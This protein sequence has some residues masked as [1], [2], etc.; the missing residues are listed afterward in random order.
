MD[1][2]A[3][4][5]SAVPA[6][7][8]GVA[9]LASAMGVGRFAFTP[10]LP[11]MQHV[12]GITLAQGGSLAAANYLGYLMGAVACTLLGP[13]P[14]RTARVG[15]VAVAVLTAGM[16][17][18]DTFGVWLALRFLAGV[19]S[20]FVLV[21]VS[22][23]VLPLLADQRRESWSGWVFAGVGIGIVLAG[24]VALATGLLR[25]PPSDA[26]LLLGTCSAVIAVSVWQPMV[27]G[28]AVATPRGWEGGALGA[29]T[30][31]AVLSYGAFGF[32]Y[33]IP[34]TFLPAAARQLIADP[35][36]FGWTWPVFGLAAAASTV[37]TSRLWRDAAP[38]KLWASAQLVMSIGLLAPAIRMTIST[39]LFSAVCVGGTFMVVT[40]AGMQ[41]ARRVAGDSAPR[42]MAAMTAA[43]ALGQLVGPFTVTLLRSSESAAMAPSHVA[44][45]AVLLLGAFA[46]VFGPHRNPTPRATSNTKGMPYDD[47]A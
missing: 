25:K 38:W 29:N 10:L 44:A 23:W 14:H 3:H 1:A 41:E 15:L 19:A 18:S 47:G 16:G 6:A 35:A 7:L 20:A 28:P 46:L 33:I 8:I 31:R 2:R 13:A 27:A 22:A 36:V 11:L 32:G 40:M 12:G 21:G 9:G 5:S 45:S 42:L 39:L 17:L 34:A 43:F 24:L 37:A 26:W 30:W 4:R